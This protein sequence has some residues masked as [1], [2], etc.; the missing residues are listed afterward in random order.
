MCLQ[1]SFARFLK[2]LGCFSIFHIAA[3]NSFANYSVCIWLSCP[4]HWP[5]ITFSYVLEALIVSLRPFRVSPI[6]SSISFRWPSPSQCYMFYYSFVIT[7]HFQVPNSVP[8]IY[9]YITNYL[10]TW[11]LTAGNTLLYLMILWVSNLCR[12]RLAHTFT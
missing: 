9:W 10:K 4:F 3:S 1:I 5:P 6:A 7:S 12:A 2:L 8:V 11:K